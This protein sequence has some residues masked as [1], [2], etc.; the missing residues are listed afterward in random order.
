[1]IWPVGIFVVLGAV[2]TLIF[3]RA[4]T[5]PVCNYAG[6]GPFISRICYCLAMYVL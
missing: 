3:M 4:R 2:F 6:Y 1:M 5:R